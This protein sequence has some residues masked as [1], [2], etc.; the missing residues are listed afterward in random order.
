MKT[1][2]IGNTTV[3]N[4]ERLID[5]LR[6]FIGKMGGRPFGKTEQLEFQGEL[7]DAGL[8]DST[9]RGGDDGAR[10]F[11]S[12][13]KQLGFVSDWARGKPWTITPVG[14]HYLA[15]PETEDYTFLRQLLKYQIPSLLEKS[16]V[17]GFNLR[18][19]RVL[20]RFLRRAHAE[21][22]IGL[23]K[24]EIGLFVITTLTENPTDFERAV[25]SIKVFRR[26]YEKRYGKV[27]KNRYVGEATVE[28]AARL[29][30]QP[31]TL[32][33]YAD[34]NSRYSLMSG[35]LTLKGNKLAVRE[36]RLSTIDA[37]LFDDTRMLPDDEYLQYLYD[38]STPHLPADEPEFLNAEVVALMS[39]LIAVADEIGEQVSI[40]LVS[41]EMSLIEL[42]ARERHLRKALIKFRE[43]KFYREQSSAA[44]LDE[45]EE[46]L[47]SIRDNT[48]VGGLIYAPAYFEWAI[49]RLFL[50]MNDLAV[51]IS[52][53]RGFNVDED[54]RPI[55]HAKGGAADLTFTYTEFKIV[56]EMTLASG[57]RQFAMEGEPVTRHVFKAI[58]D[59][60]GRP[61][62]GLF[63]SRKLD[64]NT[65]DAFHEARYWKDWQTPVST[66]VIA[67]EINHILALIERL[68]RQT[69]S[70]GKLRS[71]FDNVLHMQ[72]DYTDGPNWYMA[73]IE[74]FG[75]WV[76]SDQTSH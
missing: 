75:T 30:L 61:V 34:S 46:L 59:G 40:P 60:D 19:F 18:P 7:I 72:K 8:V 17:R 71:L 21:G 39:K 66:P 50:A 25:E 38:P 28:A 14:D 11:A 62:Y 55:H 12:A 43:I 22:L 35:L 36:A 32:V 37:I 2:N 48:L 1:W 42:Q 67:L 44:A 54:I 13:F 69:L 76:N 24:D 27:A 74:R 20:L 53:T 56:C 52:A 5:A 64:P 45:I 68:R 41:A 33:D 10:K 29:S 26:E 70:A 6:L 23:T 63:L 51:P 16:G 3:R 4:P 15:H 58:N 47:E 65:V 31:D 49:W 57:S 73:Y 9:R